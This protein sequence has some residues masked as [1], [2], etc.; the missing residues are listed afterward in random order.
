MSLIS[1]ISAASQRGLQSPFVIQGSSLDFIFKSPSVVQEQYFGGLNNGEG[2]A[3][4]AIGGSLSLTGN[5]DRIAIGA[6]GGVINYDPFTLGDGFV[7][8]VCL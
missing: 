4:G 2:S 3:A 8:V 7:F 5:G 6:E 1:T